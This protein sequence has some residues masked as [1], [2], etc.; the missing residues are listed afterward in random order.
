[1][2][3]ANRLS[4]IESLKLNEEGTVR[5]SM[6]AESISK[7]RERSLGKTLRSAQSILELEH[8]LSHARYRLEAIYNTKQ[9]CGHVTKRKTKKHQIKVKKSFNDITQFFSKFEVLKV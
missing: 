4:S 3:H 7:A 5:L 1:M 6:C 9:K 8:R 2:I